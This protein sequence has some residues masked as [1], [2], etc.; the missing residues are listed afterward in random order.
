MEVSATSNPLCIT[1][2][3]KTALS[4]DISFGMAHLTQ[5]KSLHHA[6]LDNDN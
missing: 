2:N 1:D 6:W 3:H 4:V 5:C